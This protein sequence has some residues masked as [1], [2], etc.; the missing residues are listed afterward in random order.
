L[1]E[2]LQQAQPVRFSHWLLSHAF[3]LRSDIERLLQ[4]LRRLDDEMPLGSGAICGNALNV[5]RR[6][7]AKLLRFENVTMNSMYAVSDRDFVGE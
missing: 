1:K 3:F 7:L 4:F 5:D 6:H 2:S